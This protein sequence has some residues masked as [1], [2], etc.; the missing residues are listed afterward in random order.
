MFYSF[1]VSNLLSSIKFFAGSRSGV[2]ISSFIEDILFFKLLMAFLLAPR[3]YLTFFRHS[4]FLIVFTPLSLLFNSLT[5]LI[6]SLSAYSNVNF[7]S[8]ISP[9][10]H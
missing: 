8:S 2:R 5:N 9:K 3:N 7:I 6:S 10:K 4:F 1:V